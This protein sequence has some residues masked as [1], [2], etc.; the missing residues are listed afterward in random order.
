MRQSHDVNCEGLLE[1]QERRSWTKRYVELR[2]PFVVVSTVSGSEKKDKKG[3]YHIGGSTV[4]P[5][6]AAGGDQ[7]FTIIMPTQHRHLLTFR[8]AKGGDAGDFDRWMAAVRQA[9]FEKPSLRKI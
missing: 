5:D 4:K 9:N 1:L 2:G 3:E 8:V 7:C 6:V